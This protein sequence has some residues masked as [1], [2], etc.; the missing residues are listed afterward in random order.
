ML[1]FYYEPSRRWISPTVHEGTVEKGWY[2]ACRSRNFVSFVTMHFQ[3]S[4]KIFQKSDEIPIVV[5][6][7]CRNGDLTHSCPRPVAHN[8]SETWARFC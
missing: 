8:L 1:I 7:T 6:A 5:T 4:F 2:F 3:L